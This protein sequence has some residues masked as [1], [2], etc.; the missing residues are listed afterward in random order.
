MG[1]LC[2]GA[3]PPATQASSKRLVRFLSQPDEPDCA[4]KKKCID[5]AIDLEDDNATTNEGGTS[6]GVSA[7]ESELFGDDIGKLVAPSD[8]DEAG[9]LNGEKTPTTPLSAPAP[10]DAELSIAQIVESISAD[11]TLASYPLTKDALVALEM[12]MRPAAMQQQEKQH[13]ESSTDR[14]GLSKN[15]RKRY[16]AYSTA[17]ASK[18]VKSTSYLGQI[19]RDAHRKNT[20]AGETF[21]A[22]KGKEAQTAFKLNWAKLAFAQ[23][24]QQKSQTKTWRRI[25]KEKGEYMT[26]DQLI[27]DQGTSTE[28]M[29]GIAKLVKMCSAMGPP[30]VATHPQTQRLMFLN[31][32][33]EFQEEFVQAWQHCKSEFLEGVKPTANAEAQKTALHSHAHGG[34]IG[35]G[36]KDAGKVADEKPAGK[37]ND[38]KVGNKGKFQKV[39]KEALA[40]KVLCLKVSSAALELAEQ[41][42]LED[43][44]KWARN[45]QNLGQL[46]VETKAMRSKLTLFHRTWLVE[47]APNVKKQ[48]GE[49]YL[50][51]HL[52]SFIDLKPDFKKLHATTE[53][54]KKRC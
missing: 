43:K 39:F 9:M 45:D 49:P 30:W 6:V 34:S 29:V 27:V 42:N 41:I 48:Y 10:F 26:I 47:D 20:V 23:F 5:G 33:F 1:D 22:L 25:D 7:M 19:F 18:E 38:E 16:D 32:K 11:P 46:E 52:Q 40:T 8:V 35:S 28:S 24:K 12:S 51:E 14:D 4:Q 44:W 54:L 3:E 2:K 15:D 50:L 31:L 53:L 36:D 21:I 13:A 37:V 17:L